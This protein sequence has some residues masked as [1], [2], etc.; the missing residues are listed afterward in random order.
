MCADLTAIQAEKATVPFIGKWLQV[1]GLIHDVSPSIYNHTAVSFYEYPDQPKH[2]VFLSFSGDREKL[3]NAHK[4]QILIC[5]GQIDQIKSDILIL[6]NCEV[7][8]VLPAPPLKPSLAE[9]IAQ[10]GEKEESEDPPSRT[11]DKYATSELSCTAPWCSNRS[12]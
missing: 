6:N 11:A 2:H 7:I 5:Q 9:Q 1:T 4:Q 10:M 3:E 8:D 12:P